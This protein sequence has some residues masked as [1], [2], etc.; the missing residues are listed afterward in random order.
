MLARQDQSMP[1]ADYAVMAQPGRMDAFMQ[2]LDEA[3]YQGGKGPV[4]DMRL[5]VREWDFGR[6]EIR[7]PFKVFYGEQDMN[8]PIALVRRVVG[9]LAGAQL[10]TYPDEAHMSTPINRFGEFA[11]ALVGE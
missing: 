2:V 3:M 5:Y 7:M 9:D 6:C 1:P 10:I 11:E 8:V 4:W